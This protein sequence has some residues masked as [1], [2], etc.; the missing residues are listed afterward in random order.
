MELAY[1][2]ALAGLLAIILASIA[3]Y[4]LYKQES[5]VDDDNEP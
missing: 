4:N 5:E 2:G 3:D 1:L